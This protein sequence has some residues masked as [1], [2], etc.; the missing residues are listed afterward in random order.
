MRINTLICLCLPLA[1]SAPLFAAESP[2]PLK[3]L[4]VTGGCCHDYDVQ[5]KLI[6]KGLE[7][8][9]YVDVTVVRQ[10]GGATDAKI[11]LY[12]SADWSRGF[13]VV[14][15]DECFADVKDR[16]WVDNILKPHKAGLPAVVVHCAMHCYRDGRDDW[17]SFCGVTSRMHG[18]AY[19][20]EVL[21]RDASHP[22]MTGFGAGWAN[23]VGELY[24]IEKLWPTAHALAS[25]K[26]RERGTEEV[27]V[28]TNLYGDNKT[29][30]FGTTLG[31]HNETVSDPKFLDLLTRGTLWA[32]GKLDDQHLKVQ[33]NEPQFVPVNLALNK[34]VK[35]SSEE[36]GKSNFAKNAV[37]GKKSTRWCASSPKANEWLEIDLEKPMKI[38]GLGLTWEGEGAIYRYKVEGS[39]NGSDWKM[40]V[41][42]SKNEGKKY[43]HEFA[44]ND[45]RFV[46]VT[47]FGSNT[48]AWGS[49]WE[50][51]VFGDEKRKLDP[52]AAKAEAERSKLADVQVPEGFEAT[53]F[54]A[55]PAVNYPTFVAA[56]PDGTVYVSVDKNGSLDRQPHRGSVVRL[57]DI[58]GDGR[59]DESKLFVADVD[60]P[61]GLV[62]DH[63]RLYLMHPPHLS[64]FIDKDGDGI[65]DEQKILVKN[66][67]FGFKDRPAD[68]TSNGVTLG[69]D[70]WL[71][72]AIGDFGFMEAEG[73]DGHKL[74]LRGGGVVRVRPDGTGLELYSNGTRNIL[75]VAMDPLLNGFTRDNTND[76]GGWD[77]RLHHFT[78]LEDH[79][80]PRLYMN[81]NDEIIQPLADYGGG[82]GCGALFLDEPG[83]PKGFS[84]ALYTADWGRSAVYRHQLAPH[85]ATFKPDQTQFLGLNRVTD[86]D[87]DANSN[88]YVASWKGATFNYAGEDVGYLVR[89][90]P[91]GLKTEP[92]PDFNK[93]SNAELVAL[94]KSPSHRRRLESQRTLLR[95]GIENDTAEKLMALVLDKTLALP[96]RVAALF[97]WKQAKAYPVWVDRPGHTDNN[98]PARRPIPPFG[99]VL[100]NDSVIREGIKDPVLRP[101]AI[102]AA[103]D[104]ER[105][106]DSD[107]LPAIAA[108]VTNEDHGRTKLELAVA[109]ARAGSAKIP[110]PFPSKGPRPFQKQK[111]VIAA[112]KPLLTDADPV[113]QH[114]AIQ[115]LIKLKADW[116]CFELLDQADVSEA[117]RAAALRVLQGI[118]NTKVVDGLIERLGKETAVERRKGILVALCRLHFVEGVWKGNS[119]GTRPDTRG[120]YFQPETWAE[121]EKIAVVLQAELD[122]ADAEETQFLATQLARHRIEL[123]DGLKSLLTKVKSDARFVP[124]VIAQVYRSGNLPI[125]AL[126]L[127]AEVATAKGSAAELRTQA[128]VALLRSNQD[129][130]LTP[131]ITG[132][133][134]LQRQ[135]AGSEA[136]NLFKEAGTLNRH[137]KTLLTLSSAE[138]TSIWA[139]G[140]LLLLAEDR[141]KNGNQDAAEKTLVAAWSQPARRRQLL[142][143][144]QLVNAR[145]QEDLVR[146]GLKDTDPAVSSLA[147]K[148]AD[149]WKISDKAPTGPKIGTLKPEE[150]IVSLLKL[151]GDAV[152]GEG[153]FAK[154]SC[155]KCHTVKLDEP[156]RGPY[157]PN[158][159]KTYKREQLAES[160]LLPSKTIAQGFVT[161]VFVMN[162]GKQISGFVINEAAELVTIRNNEGNE[163]KLR[164]EDIDERAKQTISMMP[165]NLA[166]DLTV[167]ELASLLTYL[168]SLASRAT[169]GSP[170]S[171]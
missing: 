2:K 81:F 79:G 149:A 109:I 77:I 25:A 144:A 89:V 63:D 148:L 105:D 51:S 11:P 90:R 35:A 125:E 168:E 52:A 158:V 76:G 86:L 114:T 87:V 14:I 132:L 147:K 27:C 171:P 36:T 30:V 1:F 80:Y 151:K 119:W 135:N 137:A 152:R 107:Y 12:E 99:S 3:V 92:L 123:K 31:H 26:N 15:H 69:I 117:A 121:S 23:P 64:A 21:N 8:R 146:E 96:T 54:A 45:V 49:L 154:L 83:F 169:T 160:I 97:A 128:V 165:D 150:V 122:K 32:C 124:A 84:P 56:A 37:D 136:I 65:S 116:L 48:G 139:D 24:W 55:P 67:A 7:Q 74:Q 101:Y 16:A 129:E 46:K 59:A 100:L 39:A 5:K 19:P 58:D 4:L 131:A 159:A 66:I 134:Q 95:R 40:L 108:S 153:V 93:A 120:P 115:S 72:L 130:A 127:V 156:I 29:R 167:E 170:V 20:H 53:L 75:E 145:T 155:N 18:A 42:Q 163:L 118:H 43:A 102:R 13:D 6:S 162:D 142:E 88:I 133:E 110:Y 38:N 78:G 161:N 70:G 68:H 98:S 111:D 17:F 57:R 94:L 157:L 33:N 44:A 138:V 166:K 143:A 10:G 47:Y 85:G 104:L 112:I 126:S 113:V 91:K 73:T 61:R 103:S 34:P 41:D 9:A 164:V 140:G 106:I 50:V 82:S 71:Y 28:W 141:R 60:S 62:W 22:I